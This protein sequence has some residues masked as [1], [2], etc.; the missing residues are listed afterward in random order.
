MS[1]TN[2]PPEQKRLP[3]PTPD[4]LK[5]IEQA[6]A[7]NAELVAKGMFFNINDGIDKSL[8]NLTKTADYDIG[9]FYKPELVAKAL[10]KLELPDKV[11][12]ATK[13]GKTLNVNQKAI[14]QKLASNIDKLQAFY[15]KHR[16][17]YLNESTRYFTLRVKGKSYLKQIDEL[18]EYFTE[19]SIPIKGKDGEKLNLKSYTVNNKNALNNAIKEL[20]LP[21]YTIYEITPEPNS[22]TDIATF[23]ASLK[24]VV[25]LADESGIKA[26]GGVVMQVG[27]MPVHQS[28]L[29]LQRII[30]NTLAELK[31]LA[32]AK[33][34][35]TS[36]GAGR[37]VVNIL[38]PELSRYIGRPTT[39]GLQDMITKTVDGKDLRDLKERYLDR[40]SRKDD[41]GFLSY[42]SEP[43]TALPFDIDD[44]GL[45]YAQ[46]AKLVGNIVAL[47]VQALGALQEYKRDN[48]YNTGNIPIKDLAKYIDRYADDMAKNKGWLRPRYRREILNG[49]TLAT[50]VGDS[51]I[52]SKDKKTGKAQHGVVYLIDRIT[53]YETN[54]KGEVIAVTTDFTAEYKASLDYNLGVVTDGVQRLKTSESINLAICIS[55]RQ[56]AKQDDTVLGN[57]ITFTA[58]TLCKKASI[59]DKHVTNRYNTLAKLLNELQAEGIAVGRWITKAKGNTITGYNPESQTVYIYPTNTIQNTYT[60]KKRTKAVREAYKIEQKARVKALKKYAKEY[61]DLEA[62][63]KEMAI[64]RPELDNLIAGNSPI[65]DEHLKGLDLGVAT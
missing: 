17:S 63:A 16:Q 46:K 31:N 41:G 5:A 24:Q 61:T 25:E 26:E 38:N 54:K 3:D 42:S 1:N 39:M 4:E 40:D 65:T 55:D 10:N 23:T 9:S 43:Q 60:T 64:T 36:E 28:H 59:I 37:E 56:V 27:D 20:K 11:T 62:L 32:K 7:E 34:I 48:P 8:K 29:Q 35:N 18:S 44:V 49:L 53:E 2:K 45:D 13:D 21:T 47:T 50:L 15:D 58:D 52:I 30:N 19:T 6:K 51:Y 33:P 57:P 22:T 14:K 12:T